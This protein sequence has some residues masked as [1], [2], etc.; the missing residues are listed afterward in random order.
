MRGPVKQQVSLPPARL[1]P[2][3]KAVTGLE[4]TIEMVQ[5]MEHETSTCLICLEHIAAVDPIY[6]VRGL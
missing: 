2:V 5:E 1:C 4:R 3:T 6:Q